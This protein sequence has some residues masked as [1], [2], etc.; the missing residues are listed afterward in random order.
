LFYLINKL[1]EIM[2]EKLSLWVEMLMRDSHNISENPEALEEIRKCFAENKRLIEEV[3][4]LHGERVR[5]CGIAD[6]LKA[7]RDDAE[8]KNAEL[9]ARLG[10]YEWAVDHLMEK[11]DLSKTS[12]LNIGKLAT[13]PTLQIAPTDG[14]SN[15]DCE[16][17]WIRVIDDPGLDVQFATCPDC[18]GDD[19]K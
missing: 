16:N 11:C 8:A 6:Q 2:D 5:Y 13:L 9:R 17:G 10:E 7:Q 3:R 18:G 19:D 1:R 4:Y 14:C 15:P 12:G